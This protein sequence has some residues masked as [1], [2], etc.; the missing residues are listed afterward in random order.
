MQPISSNEEYLEWKKRKKKFK[1]FGKI[2]VPSII[3]AMC[4]LPLL[5]IPLMIAPIPVFVSIAIA[6][7]AGS[8]FVTGLVVLIKSSY[9]KNLLEE[10][11]EF[12]KRYKDEKNHTLNSDGKQN[13]EQK[14]FNTSDEEYFE[15]KKRK[16]KFE[17]FSTIGIFSIIVATCIPFLGLFFLFV[18]MFIFVAP[19]AATGAGLIIFVAPIAATGIA[20]L[21][22]VTGLAAYIKSSYEKNLLEEIPEFEK[23]YKDEKNHTLNSNGKQ[24]TE[25][26][27]FNKSVDT[28]PLTVQ[29]KGDQNKALNN[30]I[31]VPHD[32][33][34]TKDFVPDNLQKNSDNTTKKSSSDITPLITEKARNYL[35]KSNITPA[36]EQPD[37]TPSNGTKPDTLPNRNNQE[38]PAR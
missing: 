8:I 35:E 19:I 13:T 23:R 25:Q 37:T 18:P 9:E 30:H 26:K 27:L 24:N 17:Y 2:G 16:K 14:L 28:K 29:D 22:F 3:V 32:L 5:I 11:P 36:S 34:E 33:R 38:R 6:G 31:Y 15:W 1:Y 21:I 12:A 7:I 10:I 4:M 20:G